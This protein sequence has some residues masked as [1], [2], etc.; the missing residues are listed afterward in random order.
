[1]FRSV[2]LILSELLNIIK[3]YIKY[4]WA[5][6]H[7][8]GRDSSVGIATRYGLDGPGIVSLWGPDIPHPYR[9]ALRPT[10]PPIQ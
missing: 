4:R 7:I 6:K 10:Q 5:I 9:P 3:A 8:M 1:M 2:L